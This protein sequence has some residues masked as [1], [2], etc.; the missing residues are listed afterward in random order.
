LAVLLVGPVWSD[1]SLCKHLV[2]SG[3]YPQTRPDQTIPITASIRVFA[4]GFRILDQLN[5]HDAIKA[6]V[7]AADAFEH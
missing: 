6:L 7:Y 2:W 4:N 1:R 5:C 3:L